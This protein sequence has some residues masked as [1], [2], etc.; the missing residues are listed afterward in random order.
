MWLQQFLSQFQLL[1]HLHI[2]LD[3][4]LGGRSPPCWVTKAQWSTIQSLIYIPC[5]AAPSHQQ[6]HILSCMT[7][8]KNRERIYFYPQYKFLPFV[9]PQIY[10]LRCPKGMTES[11]V[12]MV[13]PQD[14]RWSMTITL[15][16]GSIDIWMN[17]VRGWT[18][19]KVIQKCR[20]I[21]FK[22]Q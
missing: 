1:T 18:C 7:F 22:Q 17:T 14:P 8:L 3:I 6:S 19:S 13:N 21:R 11:T 20:P 10:Y 15:N 4:T 5:D 16:Q 2:F 9:W 12:Q